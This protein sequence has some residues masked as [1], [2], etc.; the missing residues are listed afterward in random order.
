[1]NTRL[2]RTRRVVP[3][4]GAALA[5]S[6]ATAISFAHIG[7]HTH[8]LVSQSL[9]SV[10]LPCD[11]QDS[12]T[13]AVVGRIALGHTAAE[14]G[15]AGYSI[16]PAFVKTQDRIAR[17]SVVTPS[18]NA[19]DQFVV[20]YARDHHTLS[21]DKDLKDLQASTALQGV[22]PVHAQSNDPAL[23]SCDNRLAD[24][25]AAQELMRAATVAMVTQGFVT[26]AQLDASSTTFRISDDPT[27]S[28][29]KFVTAI[30]ARPVQ[31]SA[32]SPAPSVA[33]SLTPIVASIDPTTKIVSSVSYANWYAGQ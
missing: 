5:L 7:S 15:A 32:T 13:L 8:S 23:R 33:Q 19:D 2:P 14:L 27:H 10:A 24:K 21:G 16:T 1:M 12:G 18:V 9:S 3:L 4:L 11:Q 20:V 6:C 25:P 31:V 29:N 30:L 26:Q 28:G 17:D 22:G